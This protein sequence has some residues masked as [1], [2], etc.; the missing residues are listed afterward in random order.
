[1]T[2]NELVIHYYSGGKTILKLNKVFPR[3]KAWL[4]E[5]EKKI[6]RYC[7]DRE[8]VIERMLEYLRTVKIPGLPEE[9]KSL[10]GEI[11]AAYHRM[12]CYPKDSWQRENAE[13]VWRQLKSRKARWG[14]YCKQHDMNVEVMSKWVGNGNT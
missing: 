4:S 1:M 7:P 8:E 12:C 9:L 13:W 3:T 5:F 2:S 11:D 10:D 14:N 6:L